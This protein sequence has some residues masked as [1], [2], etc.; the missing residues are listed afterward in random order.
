MNGWVSQREKKSPG[1]QRCI[2]MHAD[3]KPSMVPYKIAK[4]SQLEFDIPAIQLHG[5]VFLQVDV[6]LEGVLQGVRLVQGLG[7]GTVEEGSVVVLLQLVSVVRVGTVVDDQ[8]NSLLRCQT[9]QVGQTKVGDE[10]IQIVL[11][12]VD[13]GGK[14]NNTGNTGWVGLGLTCGWGVHDGQ[15]GVTQE[16]GRTT[17]TIQHSGTV[18]VG[19]V[20]VTVDVELDRGVHCNDTQSSDKLWSVRDHLGSQT[21][22]LG[23]NVPVVEELLE[24]VLGQSDG[25]GG[26]KINLAGFEIWQEGVLHDFG[27]DVQVFERRLFQTFDDGVGNITDTRL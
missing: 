24:T 15:L 7:L 11:G 17:K 20:G 3:V 25:S 9:S 12:L 19:G 10:N 22:L 23:E 4:L 26:G 27:P 18:D 8:R 1:L 2:Y 5:T 21:H 13:M 14:W 16:V 6:H